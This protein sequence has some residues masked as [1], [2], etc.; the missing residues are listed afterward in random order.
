MKR[1]TKPK[2]IPILLCF[3]VV[4]LVAATLPYPGL[5]N[6]LNVIQPQSTAQD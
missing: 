2:L 5:S 6:S 3:G 1:V 4:G